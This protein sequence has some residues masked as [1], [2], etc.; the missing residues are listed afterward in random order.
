[1]TVKAL[2]ACEGL[3]IILI[4]IMIRGQ[5]LVTGKR[6]ISIA[7]QQIGFTLIEVLVALA[8]AAILATVA[9]PRFSDA[10]A[11]VLARAEVKS[12]VQSLNVARS[13]AVAR[14]S[15]VRVSVSS[16]N[17]SSGWQSWLDADG[18]GVRDSGE[19]LKE[20]AGFSSDATVS[21]DQNGTTVTTLSFTAN[22]FLN[23][24]APIDFTYRTSPAVCSRD[25]N[26]RV[27]LTGQLTVSQRVCP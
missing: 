5:R 24:A 14:A 7:R 20:Y 2:V 15:E 18:D 25:K 1:M 17:W 4:V 11:N 12:F 6:V 9:V 3:Q 21:G 13:E 19:T 23:A 10:L 16:S 26:I 27:S 22:G 8:V